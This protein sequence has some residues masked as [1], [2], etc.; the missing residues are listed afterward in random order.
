MQILISPL[1]IQKSERCKWF[2]NLNNYRN[3]HY[4]T[5]NNAKRKFKEVMY[6]QIRDM[7]PILG[8]VVISYTIYPSSKRKFDISNP[9][10]VIDK[11]LCDAITELGKWDDDNYHTVRSVLYRFGAIDRQNPRCE[12]HIIPLNK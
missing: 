2:L 3:A 11:F 1:Y 7:E 9:C 5:L 12:I 10:S 4:H 8:S 6:N